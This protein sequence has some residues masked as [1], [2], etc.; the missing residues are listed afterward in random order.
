MNKILVVDNDNAFLMA[1][2]ETLQYNNYHVE[3]ISNPVQTQSVLSR[4]AFDCVLL[5]V[6]MPGINGLEVL[7][8]ITQ[9]QPLV[10]VIM[11]SGES[12]ISIAVE[13]IHR[14]AYDFLEK[15]IETKRLLITIH[16]AL[17]KK[18]WAMEKNILLDELFKKYKMVGC[19][20]ALKKVWNDIRQLAVSNA[21][22][23]ITG[24]TGTGKELVARALHHNSGRS[25]RRFET[26]NCA[27]IP[28]ELMES[29]LFGHVK[30]SFSGAIREHTGKFEIADGGTLFLD[31]IGDMDYRLQA[32]MLRVLQEGEFEKI[33]SNKSVRVDVRIISATNKNL[34]EMIEDG[35]FREDLYH[36]INVFE[37]NIP[38]L[39]HRKDDIRPLAEYFLAEWAQTYNKKLIRFSPQALQILQEY[40][41]PGNVRELKNVI[42][43]IAVFATET[44]VSASNV[45]RA[46]DNNPQ[47]FS[48]ETPSMLLKDKVAMIE[49][50]HIGNVLAATGG[51]LNKTAEILGIDR[52]TLFKKM[53]KYGIEKHAHN[54]PDDATS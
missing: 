5:D 47:R 32:K 8:R 7:E 10:P 13:A 35:R 11:V 20:R 15:P 50:E 17:E 19:S 1:I 48:Q 39:R 41:W 40:D 52:T 42:H 30:G 46:L 2:K 49:Q 16:K 31:E 26:L 37:I 14:G 38:P 27:S 45:L 18:S 36:R 33:G 28:S 53:K 12:T 51:K 23:L 54:H 3:T 25:G 44:T 4:Q 29:E 24:E 43:K 34:R 21:K 22:V 6:A 9:E